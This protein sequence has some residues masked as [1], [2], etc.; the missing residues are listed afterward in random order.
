MPTVHMRAHAHTDK[1][2]WRAG[3]APASAS[4]RPTCSVTSPASWSSASSSRTR[5]SSRSRATARPCT[6]TVGLRAAMVPALAT[7]EPIMRSGGTSTVV[8][9]IR[10]VGDTTP[11]LHHA[12]ST[13]VKLNTGELPEAADLCTRTRPHFARHP[14]PTPSPPPT[15]NALATTNATLSFPVVSWT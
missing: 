12:T 11:L 10:K 1:R 13:S 4:K 6:V 14:P 5:A 15:T 7:A 9:E 3:G 2:G 8:L